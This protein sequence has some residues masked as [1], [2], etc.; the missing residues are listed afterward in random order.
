M[1]STRI[2]SQDQEKLNWF[3]DQM[4]GENWAIIPKLL[5]SLTEISG[6]HIFRAHEKFDSR[7]GPRG[8]FGGNFDN[9]TFGED[10]LFCIRAKL[11]G[12]QPYVDTGVKC[13]HYLAPRW[14][15][16]K[17]YRAYVPKGVQRVK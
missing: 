10:Y 4:R 3:F 6:L 7:S 11:A 14:A 1:K 17:L 5:I 2:T 9:R 8:P 12:F 13:G 16:E 15:S